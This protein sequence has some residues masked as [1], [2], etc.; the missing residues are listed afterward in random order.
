MAAGGAEAAT[1]VFAVA[2]NG[3]PDPRAIY[4]LSQPLLIDPQINFQFQ[5]G[6]AAAQTLSGNV[7]I[8]VMLDGELMRP[9][10]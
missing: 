7:N 5:L 9:V 2:T 4:T 3:I 8:K 10:Q 6:W 1:E